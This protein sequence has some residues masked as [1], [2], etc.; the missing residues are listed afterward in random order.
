MIS[1]DTL[2]FLAD[3]KVNNT[4]EWFDANKNYYQTARNDF[5][6]FAQAL[7]SGLEKLDPAIAAAQLAVKNC[8]FRINRD[9]RFSNNKSPYKT[10]FGAFFTPGGKGGGIAGYYVHI[11]DGGCFLAGGMYMP[12]AQTLKL[13]RQEIVYNLKDFE[14]IF[15]DKDFQ[16]YFPY[17]LDKD[18]MLKK[19]PL[20]YDPAH[21]AIEYLKHKSFTVSHDMT[22]DFLTKEKSLPYI[23]KGFAVMMP[24]NSFLNQAL[25]V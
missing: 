17:G 11:E 1:S 18:A 24:F 21:P 14:K 25:V 13:V 5:Y 20:G 19:A 23:L 10:N 6:A 12:D 2:Q 9:V 8:V 16:K 15:A 3:L 4:R 7:L 22:A